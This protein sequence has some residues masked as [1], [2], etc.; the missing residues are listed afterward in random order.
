MSD[1]YKPTEREKHLGRQAVEIVERT[2]MGNY[3]PARFA[4]AELFNAYAA[5]VRE[6]ERA[7]WESAARE[8]VESTKGT[9]EI[10]A[11]GITVTAPNPNRITAAIDALAALLTVKDNA[12]EEEV[13]K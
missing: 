12:T 1:E 13:E 8:M 7:R 4:C 6:A 10:T 5:E 11:W 3:G 2:P 9:R